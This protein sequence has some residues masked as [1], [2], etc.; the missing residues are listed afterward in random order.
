MSNKDKLLAS[1]QKNLQKGQVAK[2]IKDYQQ[3]VG[4]DPKDIRN[5]QKL[6]ELF[7]R[8]GMNAEALG[9]YGAVAAYYGDN[10]FYLKAIAV[11]KQ[12]QKLD[13][14]LVNVYH[15]LAELNVKQGLIGNALA[16]YRNLLTL[17]ERKKLFSE[18]IGVLQ[19]MAELEPDNLNIQVKIAEYYAQSGL[20]EKAREVLSQVLEQLHVAQDFSRISRL[21]ELFLPFF[22]GDPEIMAGFA[23]AL[24]RRGDS[25]KVCRFCK[26]C[27]QPI[28]RTDA[29]SMYWRRLT[30]R[31]VTLRTN[32]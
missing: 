12:M 24:V 18:S 31:A 2:A 13:P 8:A 11:Y 3:I 20:R 22:P 17:F 25:E 14:E 9:E 7:C 15:R 4:L 32:A 10:G 6:A 5:R 29:C 1:A 27:C 21:Y 23:E 28:R 19:N 30:A 16:E 26:S